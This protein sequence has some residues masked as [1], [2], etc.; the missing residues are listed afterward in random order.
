MENINSENTQ[1]EEQIKEYRKKIKKS[2]EESEKDAKKYYLELEEQLKK[3]GS[4]ELLSQLTLMEIRAQSPQFHNASNP[5][6]ENPFVLFLSGMFLKYNNFEA[7]AVHPS[8]LQ[9]VLDTI[10]KYFDNFRLELMFKSID[11]NLDTSSL[12]FN[13]TQEKFLSDAN[14]RS[15]PHQKTDHVKA[16]FTK[17][18]DFL[19]TNF[20]FNTNDALEFIDKLI[21][22]A[23]TKVTEKHNLGKEMHDKAEQDFNKPENSELIK[24]LEENGMS[25]EYASYLFADA[26]FLNG[27]ERIFVINPET[28]C[29]ENKIE[30][31]EQFKNFIQSLSCT[32]GKQLDNFVN[33]LSDNILIYKPFIK[34]DDNAYFCPMLTSL[35]PKLDSILEY[36]LNDEKK[37]DTNVWKKYESA[38][39]KYLEN[40]TYEY[41][42]RLFPTKDMYQNLF[43]KI[44]QDR[45]ETDLLI[46][47]DNKIIVVESKS[48]HLPIAAKRGGMK[49]LEKGLKKIIKKAYLQAKR[50]R[51]YIR[52]SEEVSFENEAGEE[53][54]RINNKNNDYEFIFIN[55]TLEVLDSFAANLKELDV[56]ELFEENDYPWSVNLYDLDV[57]T[58]CIPSLVYLLHYIHQRLESQK[59]GIFRS[60]TEGEFLGY[61]FKNGNFYEYAYDIGRP[62]GRISL[63]PGFFDQFENHYVF[64]EKKPT[65]EIE[66]TLAGLIKNMEKYHQKG[67]TDI[68]TLLLDFPIGER[69]MI[70]KKMKQ[71]LIKIEKDKSPDGFFAAFPEPYN[72]G[73][74][75]FTSP[76][77]T[78]FY[79]HAKKRMLLCKYNQK[80]T[81]WAMIG[82]NYN[83]K[84]NFAT[85]FYYV[86]EPWKHDELL[87]NDLEAIQTNYFNV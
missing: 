6:S 63:I 24:K 21:E 26:H 80:I 76:T 82:R 44:N 49:S 67:F 59:R 34:I 55:S 45:M 83:D 11:K 20:G 16:V 38:K 58:D 81:K 19:Q 31:K 61:Y 73:F 46:I 47:Y 86:D 48:N 66:S 13:S 50:T 27:A 71:K 68:T 51:E 85:F 1:S 7:K 35:N 30:R 22:I 10:T 54:L 78:D 17:I 74:S 3:Y 14:P 15:F 4:L 2:K 40:K 79:K 77:T 75:Y 37:K 5:M 70:G 39:S 52:S 8:I 18:D 28:F 33:P 60:I 57:I 72:I 25:R 64:D 56:L 53:I 9:D 42:S 23:S 65:I 69:K 43:Y 84:K 12:E 36:L 62:I 29:K 41:F 32:F 87:E